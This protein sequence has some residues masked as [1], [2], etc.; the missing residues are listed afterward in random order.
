MYKLLDK[1][2]LIQAKQ[3]EIFMNNVLS[4]KDSDKF[5]K[6]VIKTYT[7]SPSKFMLFN[8]IEYEE[9]MQ[10][11]RIGLYK[12]IKDVDLNKESKEI[13]RYLYLKIQGEIREVARSNSSNMISISQRIRSLYPRY[14]QYHNEFFSVNNRDPNISEVMSQFSVSKDDAY[15]LVY[16]M[17]SSISDEIKTSDG[18]ISLFD[19]LECFTGSLENRVIRKIMLEEKLALLGSKERTVIEMKYLFEYNNTEISKALNCSNSMITKYL[20]QAF[21]AM[22]ID[23]VKIPK[24]VSAEYRLA[25]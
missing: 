19:Y 8:R 5:I 11:G 17:Q 4:E 23:P 25:E 7:K 14:L 24:R 12:G 10:L 20:K 3:D 15:D 21:D 1:D 2:I 18:T 6:Y 9:L 16:G 13:Q 22:D